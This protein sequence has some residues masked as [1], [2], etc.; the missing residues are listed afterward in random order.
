MSLHALTFPLVPQR[1]LIGL[2][3]GAIH[4]ARRG[5]G[6]DVAGSRPYRPGDDRDAIDWAATARLSAARA[7]DEFIVREHYADDAPRVVMVVDRRPEMALS[8][9]DIPWLRK[10]EA[11]RTAAGLIAESVTEARGLVGYLDFAEGAD[12]PFWRP[13]SSSR[14]P[15]SIRERHL[16]HPTYAA[17]DDNLVLALEFLEGHRRSMPSGSFVFVLSDFLVSPAREV[18]E[19][20][21]DHRWDVVAVVVQDPVWEQ[22][23]PPVDGILLPLTGADGRVR[24]VRLRGGESEQRRREHEHRRDAL[25]AG[26]LELGVEPVLLSASDRDHV[27]GAFLEW[28]AQRQFEHGHGWQ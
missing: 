11:V 21:V 1:R 17:P 25:L 16:E 5:I 19:R 20:V 18:W 22:S 9:P 8:S 28:A 12:A 3:F 6:T 14:E 27:L 4:G 15:W 24:L 23:F 7:T 2:A 10:H 13:P 26:F